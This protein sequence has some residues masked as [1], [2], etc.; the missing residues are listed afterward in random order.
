MFN[1]TVNDAKNN[2][3]DTFGEDVVGSK[4]QSC[5]DSGILT[6]WSMTTT[7][8]YFGATG[9]EANAYILSVA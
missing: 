4:L 5:V 8:V 9:E 6:K 7:H 1:I 3:P 2:L